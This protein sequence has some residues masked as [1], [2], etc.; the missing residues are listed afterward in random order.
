MELERIPERM[1]VRPKE[2]EPRA[3]ERPRPSPFDQALEQGRLMQRA[4]VAES[5]GLRQGHEEAQREER[6]EG[7]QARRRETRPQRERESARSKGERVISHEEGDRRPAHRVVVKTQ[8]KREQGGG[9]GGQGTGTGGGDRET[10]RRETMRERPRAEGRLTISQQMAPAFRAQIQAK[11]VPSAFSP[12][13]MQHLINRLVQ[14]VRIGR[15]AIDGVELQL[16]MNETVFHGLRLRLTAKNGKVTVQFA[17]PHREVRC[18]FDRERDRI[19]RQLAAK[20]VQVTEIQV[21]A[22]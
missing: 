17:S 20:G 14:F 3:T 10:S 2:P 21:V 6:R 13:Q 18:L 9:Q 5:P 15:T 19:H 4:P 7:A 11:Q 12:Q 1:P 22:G 16:G 8:L